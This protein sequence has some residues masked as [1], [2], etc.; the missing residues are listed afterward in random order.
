MSRGWARH[1]CVFAESYQFNLSRPPSARELSPNLGQQNL[2]RATAA[3]VPCPPAQI[4]LAKN[5]DVDLPP[6]YNPRGSSSL[7]SLS[8]P[9]SSPSYLYARL[10]SGCREESERGRWPAAWGLKG[11]HR[12]W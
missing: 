5:G 2:V 3:Q 11:W 1:C 10:E 4:S 9:L 8:L 6:N 12:D 7:W